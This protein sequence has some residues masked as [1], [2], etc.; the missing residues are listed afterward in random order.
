[1]GPGQK[2]LGC[3]ECRRVHRT[4][5]KGQ[6]FP[7]NRYIVDFL[8]QKTA[9]CEEHEKNMILF[10]NDCKKFICDIC[11]LKEHKKHEYSGAD[12]E[13]ENQA[14]R[15]EEER[16]NNHAVLKKRMDNFGKKF[17][18]TE[19]LIA[20]WS[21]ANEKNTVTLEKL[22][23]RKRRLDEIWDQQIHRVEKRR[24]DIETVVTKEVEQKEK[25]LE[26]CR[27]VEKE[28]LDLD[29]AWATSR[30]LEA[31]VEDETRQQMF[32]YFHSED[33][34]LLNP[35]ILSGILVEKETAPKFTG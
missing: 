8:K 27:E 17:H 14:K 5:N 3:P 34:G 1:M 10:C 24:K 21:A 15:K 25:F 31:Y 4:K 7:Q 35:E 23:G 9:T 11:L 29:D 19:G 13:N 12:E 26:L 6:N 33:A 22:K 20:R 30:E 2:Q 18:A 28:D 16:K 32:T